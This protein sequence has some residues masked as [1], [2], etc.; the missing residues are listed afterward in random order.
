MNFFDWSTPYASKTPLKVTS[1]K[2]ANGVSLANVC[3]SEEIIENCSTKKSEYKKVYLKKN[4]LH[5]YVV[6]IPWPFLHI[7]DTFCYTCRGILF[8][9]GEKK[10]AHY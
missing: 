6:I 4:S 9:C 7:S 3:I 1:E 2:R 5:I 10:F 8:F